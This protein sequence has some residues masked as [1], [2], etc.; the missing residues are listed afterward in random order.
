[1]KLDFNFPILGLDGQPLKDGSNDLQAGK[2]LASTIANK[3]NGDAVKLFGWALQLHKSE[4]LDLDKA[5]Q[6]TLRELIEGD[7]TLTILAKGQLLEAF[8]KN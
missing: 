6:K 4:I 7:N 2:I 3:T 1:M 5:D 8:D